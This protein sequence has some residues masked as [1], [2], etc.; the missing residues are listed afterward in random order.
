VTVHPSTLFGG[1]EYG[2]AFDATDPTKVWQNINGTGARADDSPVGRLDDVSGNGRHFAALAN[3]TTRPTARSDGTV[4]FDGS[5]DALV[6]QAAGAWAAGACTIIWRGSGNA[7]LL[8]RRFWAEGSS[9][10]ANQFYVPGTATNAVADG[11][12]RTFTRNDAGGTVLQNVFSGVTAFDGTLKTARILDSGSSNTGFFNSVEGTPRGYSRSGHTLTLNRTGL[13]ALYRT[14]AANFFGGKLKRMV[15]IGRLLTTQETADML[16]WVDSDAATDAGGDPITGTA[17]PTLAALTT[18]SAGALDIT[19][20]ATASLAALTTT[21][22]GA[23]V[24][25]ASASVTLASLTASSSGALDLAGSTSA[26]LAALTATGA[27]TVGIAALASPMLA[28]LTS[29]SAA[30]ITLSGTGN[31]TL[32]PL[33]I[34]ASGAAISPDGITGEATVTLAALVATGAGSL[35]LRADMG[36][37]LGVLTATGSSVVALASTA[38]VT[39]APVTTTTASRLGIKGAAAAMLAPLTALAFSGTSAAPSVRRTAFSPRS[40]RRASTA[41]MSRRVASVG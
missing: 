23:L 4:E 38:S 32:A 18:T 12:A 15:V 29:T 16:A 1:G 41:V 24:L 34:S 3:D 9:A 7:A 19:G 37:V 2:Y 13:G 33:T 8:D 22:A 6:L 27:G 40:S 14:S 30:A 17:S 35:A 5:N 20:Q 21:G 36:A 28:A 31:A 25:E 26:T 39:L 10:N 11:L